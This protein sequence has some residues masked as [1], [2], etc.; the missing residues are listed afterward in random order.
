MYQSKNG[1]PRRVKREGNVIIWQAPTDT[2][3]EGLFLYLSLHVP[4]LD[5]P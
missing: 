5:H 2:D 1:S 4:N 3:E